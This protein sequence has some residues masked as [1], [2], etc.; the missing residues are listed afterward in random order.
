M[1][2]PRLRVPL[3]VISGGAVSG[4]PLMDTLGVT[5]LSHEAVPTGIIFQTETK[6]SSWVLYLV[7]HDLLSY[8]KY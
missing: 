2:R 6:Y 5:S 7:R 8:Y 1:G 3:L 4:V